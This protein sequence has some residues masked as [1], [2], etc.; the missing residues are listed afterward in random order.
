MHYYQHNIKTFNSATR[1]LTRVERALYRDLIEIYYDTEKPLT[2][3]INRLSRLVMAISIDEK[4]AL[5]YV[6]SEFFVLVDGSYS[7]VYCDQTIEAYQSN[8]S[9]KS[10]AGIASAKARK[11]KSRLLESTKNKQN[12][13]GVDQV[14]NE[15]AT[16]HKP[17]TS[18][19]KPLDIGEKKKKTI[20]TPPTE[21][22]INNIFIE[23]GMPQ[24]NGAEARRY[25]DYYAQ[26]GW[27]LSNG[28]KMVDWKAAAKNWLRNQ[29]KWNN[30]K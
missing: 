26:Q 18:N 30:Q 3:D 6:L 10:I 23:V 5:S 7:H 8:K 4:E 20:F 27:K 12:L 25:I 13:T 14:L 1:H 2:S 19:H 21:E 29:Q 16:N 11:V 17:L 9:A 15:C 24:D 28:N 22:Q